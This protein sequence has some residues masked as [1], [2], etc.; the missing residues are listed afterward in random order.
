MQ[1]HSG[2]VQVLELLEKCLNFEIS[3]QGHLKLLENGNFSLKLITLLEIY[4]CLLFTSFR[5]IQNAD[6]L[7]KIVQ[8]SSLYPEKCSIFIILGFLGIHTCAIIS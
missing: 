4:E 7:Q 6:S 2:L 8:V 5:A 3:F 1:A